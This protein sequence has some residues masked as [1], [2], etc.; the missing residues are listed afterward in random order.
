MT[1]EKI[2]NYKIE[3][4]TNEN[5]LFRS[6][7]ATHTLFAKQVTIKT[8]KPLENPAEKLELIAEIRRIAQIQHPNIITLYD[9]LETPTEFYLVFEA[10]EGKTLHEYIQ[11][12]SGPITE[13]KAKSFFLQILDAFALAHLKG[14]MHGAISAN[15]I[16]VTEN[17]QI[18]VLDLALSRFFQKQSLASQDIDIASFTSPEQ[19]K[20]EYLDQRSDIYA[21]G[22]LFFCMLTGKNPYTDL[23][24]AEIKQ[25]VSFETLPPTAKFYP[26]VSEEI[27][28]IIK[29]ATAK[30][31]AERYKDCQEFKDAILKI[32][33]KP[34]NVEAVIPPID[35]KDKGRRKEKSSVFGTVDSAEDGV[36]LP[37]YT[38]ISLFGLMSFLLIW[39]SMP[40]TQSDS[41]VLHNLQDT[42]RIAQIQDSIAKAQVQKAVKDS[43]KVFQI[44][45]KKDSSEMYYHRVVRGENLEKIAKRYYV[46]LDSVKKWNAMTGKEKLKPFDGIK[47]KVRTVYK[48]KRN[49]DIYMIAQ[50]FKMSPFTLKEVNRKV[51]E[52]KP[53]VAG[54]MPQPLNLEGK[55]IVIPLNPPK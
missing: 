43:V 4:L 3:N 33:A 40:Q 34:I 55:D 14:V 16:L 10:T 21:L 1:G 35:Q 46:P 50:K 41:D 49:E 25:Q 5:H 38:F 39:Y 13:T 53:P 18:K 36:N 11:N 51:F 37:L 29:K 32:N 19:F 52:I 47:V 7:S 30:N 24:F 26:M 45:V 22:V 15:N 23:S 2:L 6:F 31:P 12:V 27:Q 20:G 48:I 28:K 8:L 9:Y 42:K 54:E 17:E 44:G